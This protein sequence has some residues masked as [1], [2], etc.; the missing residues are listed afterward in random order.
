MWIKR[1]TSLGLVTALSMMVIWGCAPRMTPT[2]AG[3]IV[4]Q[5]GRYLTASYRAPNFAAHRTAY[6]LEPFTVATAQGTDPQAF[7]AQLQAELSR[8]FQANGLN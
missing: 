5:P 6:A 3:D 8:A 1:C 2:L 4:L 7:L